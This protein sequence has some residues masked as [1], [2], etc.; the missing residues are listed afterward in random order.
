MQKFLNSR[1]IILFSFILFFLF[2]SLCLRIVFL[3]ISVV[4]ADL[5]SLNIPEI[6]AKG[7]VFDLTVGLCFTIPYSIYLLLLPQ[8]WNRTVFNKIATY[9]IVFLMVLITIFSF[10]AEYTFWREFESRFNFIAVDYLIY[11]YEVINNINESYPLP[12]LIGGVLLITLI[13]VILKRK[14]FDN[15]FKSETRFLKRLF[16]TTLICLAAFLLLWKTD[17]SWAEKSS[18]RYQNELSKAG[19]FS[20]V[21]AFKNNELNFDQFYP[22]MEI[23]K[24]FA[25]M[26][27]SLRESGSSPGGNPLELTRQI[28]GSAKAKTPNVV[29]VVLESFSAEFMGKFGNGQKLTPVLEALA[30]Q[31]LLFTKMYATGTRTVRGMEAL[32]LAVPP[33]PGNSIVRRKNNEELTTIGSIFRTKGYRTTFFYGGDGYFDNMNQYFGSNGFNITD[34]GRN[35]SIGDNY[36][37]TRTILTD[38]QVSFENA[39]GICDEDLFAA[40]IRDADIGFAAKQPFYNFV[41]T[42][43]N[44]RP[45]TYPQ[46]KINIPSG[47]GREGAVKYT[48]YAI[49]RFLELAKTKPWYANTVFIFVADHCAG[50]AGKN[51]IDITKYHIPALVFNIPGQAPARIEKMC[52]QIDLYPTLFSLLNWSYTNNNYGKNVLD[53]NYAPRILLGTYQ[54]LGYMKADSLVILSPGRKLETY[55]YNSSTNEQA[56]RKFSGNVTNEAISYYQTAYY[57][58]KN[59]GLKLKK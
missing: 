33:T 12:L 26:K 2:A 59:G 53:K 30:D 57:L 3:S 13:V 29:M 35:L 20:F 51:E 37:T 58:Y 45:F 43:S 44:H 14:N 25:I 31:S 9:F 32:S 5:D 4:Q 48:D 17:N 54:K 22:L 23:K 47:T 39:W 8:R 40:V 38:K 11:T 24:A 56:P 42:T 41:M 10:F 36:K 16:I 15:S 55:L 19:I 18:N 50:S 49:G 6:M 1:Y 34:R 27:T 21:A 7:F 46:N 28:T 52:S